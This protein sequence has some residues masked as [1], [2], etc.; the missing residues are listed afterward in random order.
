[1]HTFVQL[2]YHNNLFMY[3][4]NNISPKRGR[5]GFLMIVVSV[6]RGVFDIDKVIGNGR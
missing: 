6:F 5:T 2:P 1:M 4:M 3:N